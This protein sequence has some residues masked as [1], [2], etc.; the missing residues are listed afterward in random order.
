MLLNKHLLKPETRRQIADMGP[1]A[2]SIVDRWLGGWPK[3][4][5]AMEADG[6]LI[7]R[8]KS[9]LETEMNLL[10]DARTG[11]SLNHLAEHEIMELYG[12][13]PGP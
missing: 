5:V 1:N 11:G 4:T 8:L 13:D 6:T 7:P 2:E 10:A 9:Q 3:R 12:V